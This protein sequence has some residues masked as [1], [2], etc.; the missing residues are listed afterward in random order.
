MEQQALAE[1]YLF[2]SSITLLAMGCS[3]MIL[4][5]IFRL[6]SHAINSI[7]KNLSANVFNKTFNIFNPYSE[8]RKIIHRLLFLLPIVVLFAAFGFIFVAV[9]ILEY[10]LTVSLFVLVMCLSLIAVEVAPEIYQNANTFIKAMQF[11]THLGVGDIKALQLLRRSLP[12]L[13]NYFLGLSILFIALSATL[14]YIWPFTM[15]LLTSLIG[16]TFEAGKVVG[17]P[18]SWLVPV[19]LFAAVAMSVQILAW[20]ARSRF[21]GYLIQLPSRDNEK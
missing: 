8:H 19:F 4:S 13:S 20:K 2:Y 17:G 6:K 10:G 3:A 16:L 7:P 5:I 18:A 9:K 11:G 14:G 21:F 15:S 1:V 12:R